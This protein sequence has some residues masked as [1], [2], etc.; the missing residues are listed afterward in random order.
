MPRYTRFQSSLIEETHTRWTIAAPLRMLPPDTAAHMP[1]C[2]AMMFTGPAAYAPEPGASSA[3]ATS[4][5]AATIVVRRRGRR[6]GYIGDL[7]GGPSRRTHGRPDQHRRLRP[8]RV[9]TLSP[10]GPAGWP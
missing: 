2:L 8:H 7:F 10:P 1:L 6:F 9:L 3:A 5:V 4:S